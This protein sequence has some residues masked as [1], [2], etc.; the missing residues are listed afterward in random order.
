MNYFK[1]VFKSLAIPD[2][3]YMD[4][5][6]KREVYSGFRHYNLS[7]K[8]VRSYA[9]VYYDADNM[10]LAKRALAKGVAC[11][12]VEICL[13]MKLSRWRTDKVFKGIL[14]GLT[15]EQIFTYASV[16]TEEE[17]FRIYSESVMSLSKK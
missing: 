1:S 14:I 13:S 7:T 2:F 6:Q 8:Q 15:G 3:K 5:E 11:R 10:K 9:S 16:E 17:A 12:D 4:E